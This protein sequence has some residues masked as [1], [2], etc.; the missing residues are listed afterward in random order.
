MA[1]VS[2]I[3]VIV[4]AVQ[5]AGG[6]LK[7]EAIAHKEIIDV[8]TGNTQLRSELAQKYNLVVVH[9]NNVTPPVPIYIKMT[10]QKVSSSTVSKSSSKKKL[11]PVSASAEHEY[12][13]PQFWNELICQLEAGKEWATEKSV[14]LRFVGPHGC[15][16]TEGAIIL[17]KDCGFD[18]VYQMNGRADM[19]SGDLLGEKIVEVDEKSMQS[20]IKLQVG[21]LEMAMTHGVEKDVNGHVVLDANGNVKVTGAPAVLFYDEY[22][23]TPSEV[24]I[25]LNQITQIPR[26][27]GQSRELVLT[28]DGGRKVKSHP[29]FCIIFS[30]NTNGN[31]IADEAQMVYT[32]QDAQQDGSFLDRIK[33]VFDWGYNLKAEK[34]IMMAKLA[35]DTLV[36]I[37]MAI[38]NDV[39][40]AYNDRNVE[41]LW[42]TRDVVDI[43]DT[44]RKYRKHSYEDYV[45]LALYRTKYSTL[46]PNEKGAV[47]VIFKMHLNVEVSKFED[48]DGFWKPNLKM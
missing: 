24:N 17:A 32:A 12:I 44:I 15:G 30:G 38:F 21:S 10:G 7:L 43:C 40:T 39:R 4:D 18:R 27:P 31:G 25:V 19:T 8:L 36:G 29:G 2:I 16:K 23:S 41:T 34:K 11:K 9:N 33:P 1:N 14:N 48:M 22:A 46:N 13:K 45:A 26:K 35:D 5:N 42:S 20:F 47:A 3:T 6:I 37:L 28:N